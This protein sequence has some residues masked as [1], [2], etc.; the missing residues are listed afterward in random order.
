MQKHPSPSRKY[1]IAQPQWFGMGGWV[2]PLFLDMQ[3]AVWFDSKE[4][5]RYFS[6]SP[7]FNLTRDFPTPSPCR[8]SFHVVAFK[9]PL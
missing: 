2:P 1:P 7:R 4:K 8:G 6:I 3:V 9:L 5:T